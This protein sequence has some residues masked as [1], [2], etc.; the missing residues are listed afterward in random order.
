MKKIKYYYNP[1]SLRYEKYVEGAWKKIRGVIGFLSA[2]SVFAFIIVYLAYTYLDSPSEKKLK[3]ELSQL[4]YQYDLL[5][6]KLDEMADALV[7][8]QDR[9]DNIYR[10]IFEAEPIPSSVRDAGYGGSN[11]FEELNGYNDAE[12]MKSS[13][14][15]LLQTRY[16]MY[17][18]SK[19]YDAL[20]KLIKS[21]TEM[22]ASIPA[23]QPVANKDLKRIGS[24]FGVRIDPIY[25][26]A[27]MHE[28][29]DFTAPIGTP[30]YAT[31]NGTI[32]L[33]DYGSRGFGNHVIITHGYGYQT[34]YGHM[35]RVKVKIGQ[36]VNRGD[37][38]GLVG[39]S[40]KSTGPHC[41][42]EVIKNGRKINPINFFY[43]DLTPEE[44]QE[45]LELAERNGQAL[46]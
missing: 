11:R 24:G 19:S 27:R 1:M 3:R 32:S 8:L 14:A 38:I 10:V 33:V 41:H 16:K 28:G 39:N 37:L 35:S 44:F 18:Q 7:D 40:G 46:D 13:W 2:A 42:Y 26:V 43:S 34:L 4:E 29:I 9:D 20:A 45:V 36:K 6:G 22:L 23:I 25:K 21:K 12:L 15:K 5:N 31:G 17:I 30:I